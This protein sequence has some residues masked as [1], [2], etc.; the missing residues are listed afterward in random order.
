MQ[1]MKITFDI[2]ATC[3]QTIMLKSDCPYTPDQVMEMLNSGDAVTS[4][5]E[6]NTVVVTTD[7]EWNEIGVV[8]QNRINDE[9]TVISGDYN[10]IKQ[11][12]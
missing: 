6:G 12:D 4:I 5:Y 7:G 11:V 10:Q 3:E 2:A 9:Y 8:I 1:T